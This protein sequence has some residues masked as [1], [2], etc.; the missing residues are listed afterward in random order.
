[1]KK[2]LIITLL[3]LICSTIAGLTITE[4]L[5]NDGYG[6]EIR[7]WENEYIGHLS[8]KNEELLISF[9]SSSVD[10]SIAAYKIEDKRI[11]LIIKNRRIG[12]E[13]IEED[14]KFKSHYYAVDLR[15]NDDNEVEYQADITPVFCVGHDF[16]LND[17]SL[18]M[19]NIKIYENDS[20]DSKV[21][22][23]LKRNSPFELLGANGNYSA[24]GNTYD[25]WYYISSGIHT[26]YIN[27]YFIR[28]GQS[29][30][31]QKQ[32]KKF[33]TEISDIL[34]H[35]SEY[36]Y[37]NLGTCFLSIDNGYLRVGR[38]SS[39]LNPTI[40]AYAVKDHSI[41]LI[42]KLSWL[43][44]EVIEP[45]ETFKSYY[46]KVVLSQTSNNT[47][48]CDI[49]QKLE[50]LN[51]DGHS[52]NSINYLIT[53]LPGNEELYLY[54]S[55]S[56]Q[57]DIIRSLEPMYSYAI[58][59]ISDKYESISNINDFWY[60]LKVYNSDEYGWIPGIFVQFYSGIPLRSQLGP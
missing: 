20:T 2:L 26:G 12:T 7:G 32:E 10:A 60:Y 5:L 15:L 9:E 19:S 36:N 57:S 45:D 53:Y 50:R 58:Q 47:I 16:T 48:E 27:G 17:I 14:A 43:G 11:E 56:S 8:I 59:K 18:G 21:I 51:L 31:L 39:G 23:K 25:F 33:D 38:E 41:S 13:V 54:K 3:S 35:S 28:F 29:I 55:D 40:A 6:T 4:K 30:N 52:F 37:F 46:Y 24:F 49:S 1:M 22:G 42:I 44:A 34:L